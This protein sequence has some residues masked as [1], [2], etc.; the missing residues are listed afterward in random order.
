MARKQTATKGSS[1]K[2]LRNQSKCNNYKL[3]NTRIVNKKVKLNK[4]LLTNKNDLDAKRILK[5]L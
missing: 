4:H 5:Q 3:M 2:A 1:R